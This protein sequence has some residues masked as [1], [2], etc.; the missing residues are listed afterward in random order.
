MDIGPAAD[1]PLTNFS[2][3]GV[4]TIN[5]TKWTTRRGGFRNFSW[6]CGER[7]RADKR[8]MRALNLGCGDRFHPNWENLDFVP[9]DRTVKA[10]DLR[11]GIPYPDGCFDVVYHSHVLEHFSKVEAPQ[12]LREC[13]RVL[14]PSGIIRVVVPDL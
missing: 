7:S 11:R 3:I 2:G 12:F 10:H 1:R 9:V 4:C 6:G 14:A 8:Q 5:F 13:F